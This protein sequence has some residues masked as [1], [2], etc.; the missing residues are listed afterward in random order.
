MSAATQTKMRAEVCNVP[1]V[2]VLDADGVLFAATVKH[3]RNP[4]RRWTRRI[5]INSSVPLNYIPP[6]VELCL[7]G[8]IEAA[9]G[10]DV[11]SWVRTRFHGEWVTIRTRAYPP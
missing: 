2:W 6:F 10:A 3:V 7:Q 8:Q 1:G 9:L 4:G 5:T 11:P